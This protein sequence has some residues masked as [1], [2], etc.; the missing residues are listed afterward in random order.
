MSSLALRSEPWISRR[1]VDTT[2][3]DRLDRERAGVALRTLRKRAGLTQE[4]AAGAADRISLP[5][6]K[7]YERGLRAMDNPTLGRALRAIG[8]SVE[9]HQLEVLRLSGPAADRSDLS[10]LGGVHERGRQM[11]L[12]VGGVAH[13]GA[14]RPNLFDDGGEAEVIDFA[15]FFS[16]GTLVLKLAGM[17]MFPYAEPG[18]FVTYNP[19]QA[20]RRGHGCVLEM[21]DGSYLVKRFERMDNES[22]TVTELYP[23]ERE[24]T[25][26]IAEVKGVYAVGLRGD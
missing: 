26:P 23:E 10:F 9:E 16:P 19:R 22:V 20:A 7:N 14:L 24:V 4:D 5:S 6:W 18:G 1:M 2:D 17:S 13:G 21:M 15:R 11:S 3:R 8:A 12:P 25:F